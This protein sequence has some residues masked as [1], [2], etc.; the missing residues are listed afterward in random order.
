MNFRGELSSTILCMVGISIIKLVSSVVLTGLLYPEAYGV[1]AAVAATAFVIGMLSDLGVVGFMIRHPE[2]D[3][4]EFVQTM[5]T[6]RLVRGALAAVALFIIAPYVAKLY[7]VPPLT[8]ALRI[9]SL[10]FVL[11]GL[12]SMS[13]VMAV[14]HRKIGIVNV[15]E[16]ISAFLSTAFVMVFSYFSRDHYGMIYGMVLG[17]AILLMLSY[18]YYREFKPRLQLDR[19]AL[20][21]I[22]AFAKIVLPSSL[23]TLCL[24]QFDRVVFLKLF[25]LELFGYYGL[26]TNLIAPVDSI[27]SKVGNSILFARCAELHRNTPGEYREKYYSDNVKL[28]AL[29]MFLPASVGGASSLIVETLFDPRY[30]MVGSILMICSV[31]AM[32]LALTQPAE[33]SLMASG[34]INALL[35]G[36]IIRLGWL[37]TMGYIGYLLWG[38]KGFLTCVAVDMLPTLLY[39]SYRQYKAKII[40]ARYEAMKVAYI[41]LVFGLF[42]FATRPMEGHGVMLRSMVKAMIHTLRT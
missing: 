34:Q 23:I 42:F 3:K 26:A 35:V 27:T 30:A 31:R 11:N 6:L 8:D 37:L 41:A 9:F 40:I 5:W 13:F 21:E 38:F 28:F 19:H 16:L 20:K 39:F 15:T 36:Q 24:T 32:L 1:V 25:N 10:A 14:R 22:F 2:G 4:P 18:C 17:R 29:I 12:E 33:N 7:E